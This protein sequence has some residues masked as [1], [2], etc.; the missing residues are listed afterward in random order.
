M[1]LSKI[2]EAILKK[3]ENKYGIEK[4]MKEVLGA[5]IFMGAGHENENANYI[6]RHLT[7]AWD[8]LFAEEG[9]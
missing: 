4:T 6:A 8:N 2:I 5:V 3:S 1:N 9:E 7:A